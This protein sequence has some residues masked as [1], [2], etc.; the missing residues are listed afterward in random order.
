[1]KFLVPN[2][3]CLQNPWLGGL[4]PPDPRSVCP[5]SSTEFVE[6]QTEQSSWVRLWCELTLIGTTVNE[7]CHFVSLTYKCC[8]ITLS[9]SKG[10]LPSHDKESVTTV[11]IT[12]R[13]PEGTEHT[14]Q[15][16]WLDFISVLV[17]L[18]PHW[19]H[20]LIRGAKTGPDLPAWKV[21][22]VMSLNMFVICV[23]FWPG[24]RAR[25]RATCLRH[26]F[27]L[28]EA[29]WLLCVCHPHHLTE[30]LY[31]AHTVYLCF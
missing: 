25:F 4:P 30:V 8:H 2:Y 26:A 29:Q 9:W 15:Y 14:E 28:F 1:M 27:T 3:S 18:S 22:M 13:L 21:G 19:G 12:Q 23:Y 31:F 11:P 20:L 17:G 5:L 7:D 6:P 16:D 24:W 10:L